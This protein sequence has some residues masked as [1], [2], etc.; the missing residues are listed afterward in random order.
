ML[1]DYSAANPARAKLQ[2]KKS[3][4]PSLFP[5]KKPDKGKGKAPSFHE[6]ATGTLATEP[7]SDANDI[8]SL[9]HFNGLEE[10]ETQYK[11]VSLYENQRGLTVFSIPYFSRLSLLPIDPMPFTMPGGTR[12]PRFHQPNI[13]LHDYP[14]PDGNW[15]WVSK[16]WMIDMRS[17]GEVQHDGF[18][19]NWIFRSK[20]WSPKIGPFSF[21]R[22]RRWVR[23]MVRPGK[24]CKH[25]PR[26]DGD[27]SRTPV[28]AR[29]SIFHD[30]NPFRNRNS[31]ISLM[32]SSIVTLSSEIP[33]DVYAD[34]DEVWQGDV[35]LDWLR[36]R[37]VMKGFATDGKKLEI[38][39]RWLGLEDLKVLPAK[40]Q[41]TEDEENDPPPPSASTTRT[42]DSQSLRP[43]KVPVEYI[44]PVVTKY[45]DAV[46]QSLIFPESRARL[47][48]LF[49]L[50]NVLP[51]FGLGSRPAWSSSLDFHSYAL[52]LGS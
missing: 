39:R 12:L 28:T 38:W 27:G 18:E 25:P 52:S 31:I 46:L 19:Y 33:E 34:L 2:P 36:Y 9:S 15:R 10:S 49:G 35:E 4:L 6:Q 8:I 26:A 7:A 45:G 20:H 23:L 14:L 50:A 1:D 44:V 13:T 22:R 17:D 42:T 48:E 43:K 3:L 29:N 16:T 11:W 40:R 32:H 21:V 37:V 41:W 30:Y 5:S 47:L 51:S 24:P